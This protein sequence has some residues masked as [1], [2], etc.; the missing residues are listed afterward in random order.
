MK[1][2]NMKKL[3]TLMGLLTML[4]FG[5]AGNAKADTCLGNC[6]TLGANGVVTASPQG[7]DY[8]WVSTNLGVVVGGI[9]GGA[10]PTGEIGSETNGSTFTTSPFAAAVND[11]LKFYF[12][13]VTSDGT[14]S[15][16]EYGWAAL[17]DSLNVATILFTARTNP[18]AGAD[19]VPGFGLPGLA[20]GVTLTP[21]TTPIIPGGPAW[22]PLGGSSGACFGGVGAGCGYTDWIESTYVIPTAGTY[23][24]AFGV[25]NWGDTAFDTGLAFD[26]ATVNDVPIE[27]QIPE[28]SSLILLSTGLLG[29]VRYLRSKR[30]G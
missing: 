24:L 8:Q 19:T 9:S 10:L 12:N 26:G 7:G 15:F 27:T 25:T 21:P 13:Y 4:V 11:S 20:P 5:L 22:S 28:P 29:G 6:G 30:R 1:L 23:T 2:L 3:A 17:I 16:I 18:T 14:S